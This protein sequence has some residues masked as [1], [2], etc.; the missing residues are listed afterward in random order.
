MKGLRTGS[1]GDDAPHPPPLPPCG[2]T[3]HPDTQKSDPRRECST[4]R[5]RMG[6]A[7]PSPPAH[8]TLLSRARQPA[9]SQKPTLS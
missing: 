1:T 5:A 7:G 6:C 9:I 2:V 8:Q 3:A 4:Q